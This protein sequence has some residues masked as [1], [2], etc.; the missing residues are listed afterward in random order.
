MII[1]RLKDSTLSLL[2][3]LFLR[4]GYT[5]LRGD[6]RKSIRDNSENTVPPTR[7]LKNARIFADRA[8]LLKELPLGGTAVEVGVAYGDLT[9]QILDIMQP[10]T[11]IAIDSFGISA[12]DE[13]W[14]RHLLKDSGSNHYDYYCTQFRDHIQEGRMF[15]R[16]G[17]SWDMIA[18]LPDNSVD[19]MYVDADHS[20]DSVCKEIKALKPKMKPDGIIQFNDYT[21]F[22]YKSLVAYGV[23]GAVHAFML[24]ENYEMLY[25]SLHPLGNYDVV[26]RRADLPA[27]DLHR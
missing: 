19:Y 4:A 3:N 23:P 27:G 22:D 1:Q 15:V 6:L 2:K 5:V 7:L 13:P 25:L 11:F 21:L 18:A 24:A 17:M 12:E 20:Y 16:K 9:R 10:D 26:I 8:E 14:G